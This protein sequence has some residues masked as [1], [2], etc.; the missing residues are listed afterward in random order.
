MYFEIKSLDSI[1]SVNQLS[2]FSRD[3]LKRFFQRFVGVK[4][5]GA[6]KALKALAAPTCR[7]ATDIEAGDAKALT[8]LPG[9]GRRAAELIEQARKMGQ[10][11]TADQYPYI[12]S[13]TSLDA[14]LIPPWARAGGRKERMDELHEGI[15]KPLKGL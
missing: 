13:S 3:T 5:I 8:R 7:I 1:E 10:K 9:I 14:T 6:R 11:V 12:A 4:G 15:I 2:L